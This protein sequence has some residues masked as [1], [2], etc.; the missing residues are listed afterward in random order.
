MKKINLKCEGM[1]LFFDEKTIARFK[2][3]EEILRKQLPEDIESILTI[4]AWNK[5]DEG[6][7]QSFTKLHA[8]RDEDFNYNCLHYKGD[9][10]YVFCF[11]VFEHLMNPLLFL[12]N[13]R[14]MNTPVVITYPRHPFTPFWGLEHFHEYSEK[15]FYTLI[16]EADFE[17]EFHTS[18]TIRYGWWRYFRGFRTVARLVFLMLGYPKEEL[19]ILKPR[20]RDA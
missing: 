11:D 5:F 15:A 7:C 10:D 9:Y 12:D 6:I 4:G 2:K 17:I 13:L 3:T 20:E 16:T 1:D 19:Y 18:Y 14:R 8:W